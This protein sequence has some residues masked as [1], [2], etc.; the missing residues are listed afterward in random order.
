MAT[1]ATNEDKG[2]RRLNRAVIAAGAAVVIAVVGATYA[3]YRLQT[4]LEGMKQN[5][6]TSAS[7]YSNPD[8]AWL[9]T[10]GDSGK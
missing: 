6:E 8:D 3:V 9:K 4:V 7:L 5:S 10:G 2:L 1:T